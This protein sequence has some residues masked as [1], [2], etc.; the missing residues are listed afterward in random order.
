MLIYIACLT[1][2]ALCYER[3]DIASEAAAGTDGAEESRGDG[4][5]GTGRTGGG[6]AFFAQSFRSFFPEK[7]KRRLLR[8][9][10]RARAVVSALSARPLSFPLFGRREGETGPAVE[11]IYCLGAQGTP[12]TRK[13]IIPVLKERQDELATGVLG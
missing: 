1:A 7:T 12:H 2:L 8:S 10:P 13:I 4:R 6:R 5:T 9:G 3:C 11:I